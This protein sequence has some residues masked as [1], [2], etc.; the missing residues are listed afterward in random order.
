MKKKITGIILAGSMVC[1]ACGC[2]K[3][4]IEQT[5]L[6]DSTAENSAVRQI[7]TVGTDD[8]SGKEDTAETPFSFS[9]FS[10]LQF[11]FS[12]GAG[13]WATLLDIDADGGFSGEYSDGEMGVTGEGYP[14]GTRYQCDFSGRFTQPV[15]VNDYTYSMRIRELNYAEEPGTEEIKDG[16]LYCYSTVYGL[17][18]AENI[19]IYLPGAPIAELPEG[20]RSWVGYYELND[21]ADTEL[22]YYGLYNETQEYG[23]SSYQRT[24]VNDSQLASLLI[25]SQMFD[26][27][28]D[29]WE[30]VTFA[31]FLPGESSSQ[32]GDAEFK[33]LKDGEVVY[34]FPG[35]GQDSTA[36]AGQSFQEVL[37]VA[38]RDIDY[39]NRNDILILDKYASIDGADA[40]QAYP[41]I[42]IY[43]Q[44]EGQKEFVLNKFDPPMDEFL[45]KQHY[46]DN[47]ANVLKGIDEYWKCL[48]DQ[49]PAGR[50]E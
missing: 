45:Q 18:G 6:A 19:L 42:R 33:L 5:S 30:E 48:D 28:L 20:F 37:A 38:F 46:N 50:Y 25:E 44:P 7:E 32:D 3:Q 31:S 24:P 8:A 21:M 9:V 43:S 22:P 14:N 26:V 16:T 41:S 39:D 23:F 13:G 10:N 36:A 29:G 12:S 49:F 47:I 4:E 40:G 35:Y 2:G 34:S 15:K 17:D 27:Y 11:C 1:L